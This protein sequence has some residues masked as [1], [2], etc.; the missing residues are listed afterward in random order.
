MICKE[1]LFSLTIS[2]NLFV[3][4]SYIDL[5]PECSAVFTCCVEQASSQPNV[6][7]VLWKTKLMK[8]FCFVLYI[9]Q[10]VVKE[11]IC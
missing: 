3:P 6:D 8:L 11:C 1:I 9:H 5:F 2:V 4:Y 10:T 7:W